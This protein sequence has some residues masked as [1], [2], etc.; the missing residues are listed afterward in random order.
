MNLEKHI[1]ILGAL[2]IAMAIPNLIAALIIS[3]VFVGS[4]LIAGDVEVLG[5]L[6]SIG[7]V[8]SYFLV[9][10]SIPGLF[11]GIGL[12]KRQNWARVLAI[13]LGFLNLP[14]IPLG[15]TLGIYAFWILFQDESDRIFN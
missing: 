8:I 12:L 2:F 10:L 11:V 7:S 6:T 5:L 15:T 4:G 3:T 1:Q 14:N 13:I 9:F